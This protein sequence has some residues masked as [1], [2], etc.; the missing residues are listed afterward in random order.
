M[1]P[2]LIYMA[3]ITCNSTGDMSTLHSF[4]GKPHYPTMFNAHCTTLLTSTFDAATKFTKEGVYTKQT[5]TLHTP[6]GIKCTPEYHTTKT[7]FLSKHSPAFMAK[8]N[9]HYKDKWT[10]TI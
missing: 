3:Y 4:M 5:R 1:W 2:R 9:T 8:I 7:D 6:T 10:V